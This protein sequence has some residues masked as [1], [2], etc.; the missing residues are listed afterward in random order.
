MTTVSLSP[1]STTTIHRCD[2]WTARIGES[3]KSMTS[4]HDKP[5][6]EFVLI[7][8]VSD[9]VNLR[10]TVVTKGLEF[11][12]KKGYL[13]EVVGMPTYYRIVSDKIKSAGFELVPDNEIDPE[14]REVMSAEER[15]MI[16][17]LEI[18]ASQDLFINDP[19]FPQLLKEFS[20]VIR[21]VNG[22]YHRLLGTQTCQ[23]PNME[24]AMLKDYLVEKRNIQRCLQVLSVAME[25]QQEQR[26]RTSSKPKTK[27]TAKW[28]NS[29]SIIH[30]K[31][32]TVGTG[33]DEGRNTVD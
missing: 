25:K 26:F 28:R 32:W 9:A 8:K 29:G 14:V 3:V 23:I 15:P 24:F 22:R 2:A 27:R 4:D 12:R 16:E 19:A 6:S 21:F 11:L 33:D 10:R 30:P 18:F 5:C 20:D 1:N 17:P 7:R 13:E 31:L